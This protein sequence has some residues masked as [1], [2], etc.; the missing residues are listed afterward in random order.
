MFSFY[1]WAALLGLGARGPHVE[2]IPQPR[3]KH[4][5][6]IFKLLGKDRGIARQLFCW[7]KPEQLLGS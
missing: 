2:I 7:C 1:I 6:E 4:L 5:G 3:M